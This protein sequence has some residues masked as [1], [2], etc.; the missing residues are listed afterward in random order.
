MDC[1]PPD[2]SVHGI[3]QARILEWVTVPSSS[4]SSQRRDQTHMSYVSCTGRQFLISSPEDLPNPGVESMSSALAGGFF[5]PESPV[6]FSSV[7]QSCPT[8]CDSMRAACHG[9][10]VHHQLL[11]LAETHVHWVSDAIQPSWKTK[12]YIYIYIYIYIYA[13]HLKVTKIVTQC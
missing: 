10:P 12:P 6:Q 9:S 5:I 1:S 2:S 8:L 11:E 7:A 4:G 13:I 3:L